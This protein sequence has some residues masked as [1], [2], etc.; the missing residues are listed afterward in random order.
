MI[1]GIILPS[2][3]ASHVAFGGDTTRKN[4]AYRPQSGSKPVADIGHQIS[5]IGEGL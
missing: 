3:S 4:R 1:S 2:I 5:G